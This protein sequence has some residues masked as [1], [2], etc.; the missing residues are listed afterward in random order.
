MLPPHHTPETPDGIFNLELHDKNA[1]K[2]S[3]KA[4]FEGIELIDAIAEILGSI[5]VSKE[6]KINIV[7]NI[8]EENI[9]FYLNPDINQHIPNPNN[10]KDMTLA[11]LRVVEAIKKKSKN[12]N[13]C[14]L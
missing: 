11:T 3:F 12:W 14:R 4:D 5:E 6:K 13:N 2:K 9:D 8:N 1:Y 7:I 10:I